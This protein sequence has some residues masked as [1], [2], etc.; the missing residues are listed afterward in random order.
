[1]KNKLNAIVSQVIS[2][3][4]NM[5]IFRIVPDGWELP[6]FKAGQFVALFLPASSARC[7][8]ATDE[9]KQLKPD[10]LIRRAYSISSSSKNKEYLEFYVSIVRSG[11]LTP[12]LFNLNI[13]DKIG[14]GKKFTGMFTLDKVDKSKNIVLIATGTGVAPYIS[15]LRSDA[16][17]T[18]RKITVIHGASNS[19]DLGYRSEL[20]LLENISSNVK[21][22]PTIIDAGK[23]RAKWNGEKRFLQDI[24]KDKVFLKCLNYIPTAENTHIFLC[25]NPNMIESMS[26]ILIYENFLIHKRNQNGQIHIEK[27]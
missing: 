24:W 14:V 4:P 21:Y 18:N 20:E 5:K 19:W 10:K 17:N 3:S 13:G 22:I 12:R 6:D 9:F 11:A 7:V 25:G 2:V 26:N 8:D 1:M 16:M 15:M 23:E 27:F